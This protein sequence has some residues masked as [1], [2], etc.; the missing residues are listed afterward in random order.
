M[1]AR[2]IHL[3]RVRRIVRRSRFAG[4]YRRA[5]ARH[6]ASPRP[7]PV[8]GQLRDLSR[9]GRRRRTRPQVHRRQTPSRLPQHRRT[10]RLRQTRPWNHARLGEPP[11]KHRSSRRR[12]L[13]ARS[14]LQPAL[15]LRTSRGLGRNPSER[16]AHRCPSAR[17]APLNRCRV[18]SRQVKCGSTTRVRPCACDAARGGRSHRSLATTAPP[19]TRALRLLVFPDRIA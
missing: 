18:D 7:N 14:S 9:L 6:R 3:D 13:R 1:R 15:A 4:T 5:R 8:R 2:G 12:S 16:P 17:D 19:A 10:N 11:D